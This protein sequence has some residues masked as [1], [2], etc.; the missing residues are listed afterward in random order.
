M[1]QFRVDVSRFA[2]EIDA[3][4][5][6]ASAG[7]EVLIEREGRV[8]GEFQPTDEAPLSRGSLAGFIRARRESPPV[9]DD[10]IAAVEEAIA[11]GNR[12]AEPSRW[13]SS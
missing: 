13:A 9:D 4:L 3:V 12:P 6:H 10:F 5:A 8:V 1:T 7:D 11:S 2:E